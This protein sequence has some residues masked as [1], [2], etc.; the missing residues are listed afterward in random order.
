MKK[1]KKPGDCG[2]WS[3]GDPLTPT[4]DDAMSGTEADARLNAK[5][6]STNERIVAVW[7]GDQCVA[8]YWGGNEWRQ[9]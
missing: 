2:V 9:N 6:L 5:A 8:L 7:N 4:L 3:I 1:A